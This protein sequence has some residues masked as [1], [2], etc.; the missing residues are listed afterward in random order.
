LHRKANRPEVDAIL[1]KKTDLNDMQRIIA[2]L[3]NKIDIGSFEALV[4]A[5]EM[6]PDR[7]ELSHVLP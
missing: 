3:E 6:K 4:R 5:V 2:A 1:A 7:H